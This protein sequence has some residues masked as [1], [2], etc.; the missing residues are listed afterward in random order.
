MRT[1]LP[2]KSELMEHIKS[3]RSYKLC[4]KYAVNQCGPQ[5]ECRYQH[6]ILP[7]GVHICYKCGVISSSKTDI[8]KHIKSS[9]GTEICFNFLLNKCEFINC[10]F[11][12]SISSA[13]YVENIPEREMAL[14]SAPN[15]DSTTDTVAMTELCAQPLINQDFPNLP[16]S[17]PEV[18]SQVVAKRQKAQDSVLLNMPQQ[19]QD[20]TMVVTTQVIQAQLQKMIPQ[21][22]EAVLAALKSP[23]P[24]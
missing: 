5:S 9:H 8:M 17:R 24:Q 22:L 1:K 4:K 12:H 10:M 3:H 7:P 20:Q 19:L 6:S 16:I 14:P 21:I 13:Q 18:W 15:D 23:T 2:T 11:S